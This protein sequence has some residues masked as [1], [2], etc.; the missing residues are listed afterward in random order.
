[1][2][3]SDPTLIDDLL[4]A[5]LSASDLAGAWWRPSAGTSRAEG[6]R[7]SGPHDPE[8]LGRAYARQLE[9]AGDDRALAALRALQVGADP[10]WRATVAAAADRL[11]GR[12]RREPTWWPPVCERVGRCFVVPWLVPDG[13]YS[14]LAIEVFQGALPIALAVVV[15]AEGTIVEVLV[16]TESVALLEMAAEHGGSVDGDPVWQTPEA[17]VRQLN[18]VID[19]TDLFGLAP[20]PSFLPGTGYPALRG[21]LRSWVALASTTEATPAP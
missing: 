20:P 18:E 4:G 14:V 10:E 12:G 19:R 6:R 7:G 9:R 17:L 2:L 8:D 15:D 16:V 1:M 13:R 5:Q 21:L 11:A 3:T